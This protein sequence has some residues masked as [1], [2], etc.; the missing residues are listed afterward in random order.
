MELENYWREARAVIRQ[1]NDYGG[2]P[3]EDDEY[4]SDNLW[5]MDEIVNKNDISWKVR[6]AI[7]DEMLEEFNIGNSGFDDLL[8]DVASSF[9]ISEQEKRYLAD[10]LADG[11]S[12]YYRNYAADIYQE[13]GD[14]EQ[15]LKT[16]LENLTYG[17]DYVE[18]AQYYAKAGD[19]EKELEY[20]WKGLENSSGRLDGLI[21][22]AAPIYIR[23]ENDK[24]LRRLY[25]FVKKTNWDNSG[26]PDKRETTLLRKRCSCL[27]W[28]PVTVTKW[29]NGSIS[30]RRNWMQRTGRKNMGIS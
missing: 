12:D 5:K 16:K 24:E 22:Y 15:F 2:G 14:D 1:F 17:S 26:M 21:E 11:N 10:K 28:I 30:V 3:E 20:I 6:A 9:C 4:A 18:V 19:R 7:L 13:L 25:K 29:R 27:F 8:I 23:E